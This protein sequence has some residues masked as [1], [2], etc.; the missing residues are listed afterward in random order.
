MYTNVLYESIQ[1]ELI[2][3]DENM[4]TMG[5]H[6]IKQ[7]SDGTMTSGGGGS[8]F[9]AISDY[10]SS[11]GVYLRNAESTVGTVTI[12]VGDVEPSGSV[13]TSPFA[14]PLA[15]KTLNLKDISTGWVKFDFDEAIATTPGKTYY[16][17]LSAS[18]D[19]TT[20]LMTV[21]AANH[22]SSG[23]AYTFNSIW[24][25][26]RACSI[27]HR[28]Y[29]EAP[30]LYSSYITIGGSAAA[31]QTVDAS[32]NDLYVICADLQLA[33]ATEAAAKDTYTVSLYKGNVLVDEITR[34]LSSLKTERA[35]VHFDF[36]LP[37]YDTVASDAYTVRVSASK[38]ASINWYGID[39]ADASH[40]A[41]LGGTAQDILLSLVVGSLESPRIVDQKIQVD[42]HYQLMDAYAMFALECYD[43]YPEFI[44]TTYPMMKAYADYFFDPENTYVRK[45]YTADKVYEVVGNFSYCDP[46]L[47]GGLILNPCLEHSREGSYWEG[48]DLI[49]NVFAAESTDKMSQVATMLGKTEDATA[50][51]E[52]ADSLSAAINKYM[53][54]NFE[55]KNIYIELISLSS[56]KLGDVSYVY[57]DWETTYGFSFVSLSPVASNWYAMDDDIM[58]NTYDAYLD[59]AAEIYKI[60]DDGSQHVIRPSVCTLNS[61][62]RTTK[63][64]SHIVGKD[65][66]WEIYYMY[67]VGNTE[68]LAHLMD[69]LAKASVSGSYAE[70]YSRSGKLADVGNQEQTGWLLYEIARI[71]GI[72]KK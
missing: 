30:D 12:W 52:K 3:K 47:M 70:T 18:S 5:I 16:F 6:S 37:I 68:R 2:Y 41:T 8:S 14:S 38:D 19:V 7:P 60:A 43:E 65:L 54:A 55:G 29:G 42:G 46:D 66:S 53:V 26:H 11:I 10:I 50:L 15:T 71:A 34:P 40:P 32:L 1:S 23:P 4:P 61:D 69:F 64:H 17:V 49:T 22:G 39:G 63:L 59:R 62:K 9:V 27:A 35:I 67:K 36:C 58:A 72:Y 57:R 25:P 48:Y 24:K 44:E 33:L 56:I 20:N 21:G 28:I 31:S 13:H 45:N 51:K